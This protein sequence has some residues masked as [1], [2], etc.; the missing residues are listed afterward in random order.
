MYGV[1]FIKC[2]TVIFLY[3]LHKIVFLK[4]IDALEF[5]LENIYEFKSM[6]M[7]HIWMELMNTSFFH[8]FIF[9]LSHSLTMKKKNLS[10]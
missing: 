4:C 3:T 1:Y 8:L 9:S 7:N 10:N 6:D 2:E 5:K